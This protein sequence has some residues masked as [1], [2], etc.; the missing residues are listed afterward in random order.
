MS[1]AQY[2]PS[3]YCVP[4]SPL[5]LDST[6][7]SKVV[8]ILDASL[9]S[10]SDL[11]AVHASSSNTTVFLKGT[12]IASY[13]T[14]L[15]TADIKVQEIDFA[16]LKQDAPAGPVVP[17]P[18]KPTAPSAGDAKIDGA[19]QIAIGIKKDVDFAAW[20]TNVV[21]KGEMIDY[22][23]V[24]GCYILRPWAYSIWDAIQG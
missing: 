2:F 23:S 1:E 5:S 7:F 15:N 9:A 4:V 14:K 13:L 24:S 17:S 8:T 21:I 19:V 11:F 3:R 6:S 18:A 10:S 12:E 20:Y 22:Y 16:A